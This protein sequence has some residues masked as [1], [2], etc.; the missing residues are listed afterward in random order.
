MGSSSSQNQGVKY[1]SY[2]IDLFTK[3]VWVKPLKD[4]KAKTVLKLVILLK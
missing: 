2:V 1:L 3:Y 4:K